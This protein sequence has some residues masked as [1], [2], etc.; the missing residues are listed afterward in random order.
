MFASSER[1]PST[2]REERLFQHRFGEDIP[3]LV[4]SGTTPPVVV[5]DQRG[6]ILP[7]GAVSFRA[8]RMNSRPPR[9]TVPAVGSP[10]ARLA[11]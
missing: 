6:S 11:S 5:P 7:G 2:P 10:H 1:M 8:H 3:L 9:R 4:G